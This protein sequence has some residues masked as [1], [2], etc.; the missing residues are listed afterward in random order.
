MSRRPLM[1][2]VGEVDRRA[3][4]MAPGGRV[5]SES[6]VENFYPYIGDAGEVP[7]TPP[8][9]FWWKFDDIP[10]WDGGPDD[11]YHDSI[12]GT[13]MTADVYGSYRHPPLAP[14]SL[15]SGGSGAGVNIP[16]NS[17][18]PITPGPEG[19]IVFD[20]WVKG[21]TMVLDGRQYGIGLGNFTSVGSWDGVE[22]S[23]LHIMF[24]ARDPDRY[25][26]HLRFHFGAADN[27]TLTNRNVI[28]D[29]TSW[30]DPGH[31]R[32][33]INPASDSW[34]IWMGET[35]IGS[36]TKHLSWGGNWGGGF[37]ALVGAAF[38]DEFKV[39]GE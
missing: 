25:T 3:S 23:Y 7:S 8:Y 17:A 9:Q 18:P 2:R 30:D 20:W 6:R 1:P 31:W 38:F 36:G 19:W 29:I 4:R 35:M 11:L 28:L 13:T 10:S 37:G 27:V 15:Y 5:R 26:G 21:W 24:T 32:W 16:T 33:K 12:T 34:Q 22:Y 39:Y 14:D